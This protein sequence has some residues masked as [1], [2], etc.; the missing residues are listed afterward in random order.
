MSPKKPASSGFFIR[1]AAQIELAN[2][3]K[4][5]GNFVGESEKSS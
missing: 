3:G 2:V 1:V 4:K 5:V